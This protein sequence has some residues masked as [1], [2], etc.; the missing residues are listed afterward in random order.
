MA[1]ERDHLFLSYA[2]EDTP[3]LGWLALRLTA[4]G[5]RVWSDRLK[6]LGGEPYPL[7][8][9]YAIKER[10]FRVLALMSRHSVSK[11]NPVKERTLALNLAKAR[12]QP[13]FLIPLNVDGL[14]PHELDWMTSDLTF[15]PFYPSWAVGLAAL[16][17][18]LE[19]VS[20]PHDPSA[21]RVILGNTLAALHAPVRREEKLWTNLLPLRIPAALKRLVLATPDGAWPSDETVAVQRGTVVWTFEEPPST[22]HF[23]EHSDIDWETMS[24]RERGDDLVNVV[25]ELASRAFERS[26]TK[27]GMRLEEDGTVWFPKGMLPGDRIQFRNYRGKR[28]HVNVVGTRRFRSSTGVQESLHH[29]AAHFSPRLFQFGGHYVRL[30]VRAHLTDA[31]ERPY[32]DGKMVV[33]R[34]KKV[35]KSWFNHQWLSRLM[36]ILEWLGSGQQRLPFSSA[37]GAFE[38][39]LAPLALSAAF[40]ISED[41]DQ[42][43]PAADAVEES[44]ADA[45]LDDSAEGEIDD[46]VEATDEG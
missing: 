29:L 22:I 24:H 23:E 26:C 43:G 13:D 30:Q 14:R 8:I 39:T 45:I 2:V 35:C 17:E 46:D 20:T 40:G 19:S 6:L 41:A 44:T 4:A 27:R 21:G 38:V 1:P 36:A 25:R 42:A 11:P 12:N 33:R 37:R 32:S 31:N 16:L 15:I 18:K 7:D 28:T 10:S 3:L 34:R 9:D 5:Y